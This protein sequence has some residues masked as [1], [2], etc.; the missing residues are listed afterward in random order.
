MKHRQAFKY[1]I[2]AGWFI[3]ALTIFLVA[4][5]IVP[6]EIRSGYF[7]YRVIW[8]EVLCLLFWGSASFYILVSV[9]QKDPVT[10]FG[11]IAPT[12]SI[13]TSTYAILSFSV[14][15]IHTFM[16]EGDTANR[17][18]WILQIV[19]F[20]VAALSVVFL[21][22]SRAAATSGLG[23]D[24]ANALTPKELHDLLVVHESSLRSPATQSLKASIKQLREAL[25]YSLNESASLADLSDYQDLSREIKALC[26][27]MTGLP[28]ISEGQTDRF[29]SLRESAIALTTRTKLVSAKQ[30]R[31]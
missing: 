22:I 6:E 30:V 8:A 1:T 28:S 3:T 9:A 12:I 13:V 20:A 31:R 23:F 27:S 17:V 19:F 26:E 15:V 16:S 25:I 18:H 4:T 21:S 10:R 5:L 11:G 29:D 24:G 2:L 14:M 7:W